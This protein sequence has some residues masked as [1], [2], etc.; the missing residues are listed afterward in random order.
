M[1]IF[2]QIDDFA[3]GEYAGTLLKSLD[4]QGNVLSLQTQII[5]RI[6][7]PL[8]KSLLRNGPLAVGTFKFFIFYVRNRGYCRPAV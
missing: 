8:I 3:L 4:F 2:I 7:K 1:D 6:V 5:Y